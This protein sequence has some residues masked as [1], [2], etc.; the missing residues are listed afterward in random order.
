MGGGCI[1]EINNEQSSQSTQSN[2]QV[3]GMAVQESSTNT[4]AK[5]DI[6]KKIKTINPIEI[7]STAFRNGIN[8]IAR[9]FGWEK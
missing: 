6:V 2:N 7:Y 1:Q 8:N 9:L 4:V 5:T 3:Q